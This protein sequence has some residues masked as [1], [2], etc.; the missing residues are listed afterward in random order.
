MNKESVHKLVDTALLNDHRAFVFAVI[1]EDGTVKWMTHGKSNP[2]ILFLVKQLDAA[3]TAMMFGNI[4]FERRN[5][6]S[7]SVA[8]PPKEQN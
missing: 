8:P 7:L 6:P 5:S 4:E 1:R 2:E 3:A